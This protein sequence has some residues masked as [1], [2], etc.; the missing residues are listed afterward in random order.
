MFAL[1]GTK[2]RSINETLGVGTLIAV[3]YNC[4]FK[5]GR[6]KLMA[7]AAPVEVGIIASPE[8]RALLRSLWSVSNNFW[9]PVYLQHSQTIVP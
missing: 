5:L 9:S 8:A 6:T 2:V 1:I 7:F 4:P 3:P